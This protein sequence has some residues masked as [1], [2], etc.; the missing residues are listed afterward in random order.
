MCKR[1]IKRAIKIFF[2][3]GPDQFASYFEK[4][5][6]YN[7]FDENGKL[8]YL[9]ARVLLTDYY[10][11]GFHKKLLISILDGTDFDAPCHYL[12]TL[13]KSG[14]IDENNKLTQQ[15]Y[16][17]VISELNVNR[18][19][20]YLGLPLDE[21]AK[22]SEV[23]R[24]DL[25]YYTKNSYSDYYD[26][27]I[28][29]E[30]HTFY[31][32]ES[33]FIYSARRFFVEQGLNP[34]LLKPIFNNPYVYYHA[35]QLGILKDNWAT[36]EKKLRG[37]KIWLEKEDFQKNAWI[38]KKSISYAI[39]NV[40]VD[41]LFLDAKEMAKV[42]PK[43]RKVDNFQAFQA[44]FDFLGEEA[45]RKII[46]RLFEQPTPDKRGWSDL[47][48][49]HKGR[50][51]PIEVKDKDKLSYSQIERFFWLKDNVPEHARNQRISKVLTY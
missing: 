32:I 44:A 19:A 15:G 45:I 38:I 17:K 9:C 2:T 22:V 3:E 29:D 6:G 11:K 10:I 30:G 13:F 50:Y 23:Q 26:F 39:A 24:K 25:E 4:E 8:S 16:C 18:Q 46:T 27:V 14:L 7:G 43:K 5:L 40:D 49:F 12:N 47:T 28:Y 21:F 34:A 35:V 51:I 31:V 41:D 20:G 33:C 42:F 37:N 36:L 1:T 48:A